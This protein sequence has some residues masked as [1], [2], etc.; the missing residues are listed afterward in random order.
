VRRIGRQLYS[1][2][3]E[4]GANSLLVADTGVV[5][6]ESSCISCGTCV[7]VCPTGALIDRWSAYRGH[8]EQAIDTQTICV[9][10]SIGCG[11][12]VFTRDNNLLRIDGNW[13]APV[14][15]RRNLRNWPFQTMNEKCDR[16]VTPMIRKN[17]SL[18]AT[19]WEEALKVTSSELKSH[20][21]KRAT[22][23]RL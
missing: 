16:L 14:Q 6:G 18:K 2:F 4:R 21:G 15:R 13:D 17:G 5:L 11:I 7:Q 8:D 9:G 20:K 1:G 19:T 23:L 22:V 12:N 10:C 3:E